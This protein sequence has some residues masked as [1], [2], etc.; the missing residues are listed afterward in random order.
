MLSRAILGHSRH[1]GAKNKFQQPSKEPA[2]I[3]PVHSTVPDMA[4]PSGNRAIRTTQ[5]ERLRTV[6][7][8]A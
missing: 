3:D 2:G 8:R 6:L 5:P 4:F 1:R 7:I